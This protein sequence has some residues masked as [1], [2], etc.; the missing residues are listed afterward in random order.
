MKRILLLNL[1]S[2]IHC[3]RSLHRA[4]LGKPGYRW[5]P[6]DYICLSG[7]FKASQYNVR[8]CDYQVPYNVALW[9]E[10]L[11]FN[12][13]LI[14]A[15]YSPYFESSDLKQLRIIAHECCSTNIIVLANHNDRLHNAH[16]EQILRQHPHISA[17]IYDYAFNDIIL[18]IEGSRNDDLTNILFL[19]HGRLYGQKREIP[20]GFE[21][22]VP[23]H[24]IFR[25]HHY[26]HYDSTGG[27]LTA[28]MA[29]F[30]CKKNCPF[31]WGPSLYSHVA[32]RSPDNLI[33]EMIFIHSCGISE[34]YFHD[35]TFAHDSDRMMDFCDKLAA[36][37]FQLRWFCSSRFDCLTSELIQKMAT[38]GCRCIEFGIES[39][40]ADVRKHYGKKV[41]DQYVR[42]IVSECH[43]NG[44]HVSLFAIIGLP[45]E[46]KEMTIQSYQKIRALKPDYIS[47]NILWAEPQTKLTQSLKTT[48]KRPRTQAMQQINF[49]HPHM[50]AQE[51]RKLHKQLMLKFYFSP[52]TIGRQLIRLTSLK[53]LKRVVSIAMSF[54]RQMN[55][56]SNQS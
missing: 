32:T 51:V 33:Q 41:S 38:S 43:R 46:T 37:P 25:S 5:P 22:P 16:A 30:G 55:F 49:D 4:N 52:L 42:S 53:R 1:P 8:Y 20:Q 21:L 17:L 11:S 10:I 35:L 27:L 28:T 45:E 36:Q 39:G 18:Y 14:I 15:A 47:L 24:D 2:S 50:T 29:S 6:V 3:A 44:I 34:V 26:Y 54:I 56:V 12:P 31:C 19:N 48:I 7:Y 13:H 23:R 9:K 40:H